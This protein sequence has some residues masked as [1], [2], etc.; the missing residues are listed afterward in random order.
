MEVYD[1][2]GGI[3][4]GSSGGMIRMDRIGG[5]VVAQTGGGSVLFGVLKSKVRVL[6]A[7]GSIRVN[8]VSGDS[9]FETAGGEIFI[10]E[11]YG[12]VHAATGGGN[13][14]VER[15]GAAVRAQT[16]GGRIEVH[17][18]LGVVTA[19]N[20]SGSIEI[21]SAPGVLCESTGGVIRLQGVSGALRAVTNAGSILA[22][23]LS[24]R[25]LLNSVLS[26]ASGDINVFIPSNLS[27]TVKAQSNSGRSGRIVSEFAEIP[28]RVSASATLAEGI[29]NG[30]GPLL[31]ISA[32]HGTIYL[33][34]RK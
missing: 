34:R 12:P 10:G 5:P 31:Q 21:G 28:V 26:T 7:G 24:G 22:D 11:S 16:A 6:S 15:A 32:M 19:E 2:E 14:V 25:P 3:D 20:S 13:I 18:A 29:L 30:G 17:Q 27:V 1:F 33:R 4:A 8:H 23:L 9:W